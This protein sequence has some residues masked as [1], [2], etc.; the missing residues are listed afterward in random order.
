MVLF[1]KKRVVYKQKQHQLRIKLIRSSEFL[2][3][4][5]ELDLSKFALKSSSFVD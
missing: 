5:S 3:L 2:P 4:R 1:K